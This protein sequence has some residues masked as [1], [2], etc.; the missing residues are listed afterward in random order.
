M[1]WRSTK[2]LSNPHC[3]LTKKPIMLSCLATGLQ[4]V[5][6]ERES[7]EDFWLI[8]IC[9]NIGS[10]KKQ[11]GDCKFQPSISHVCRCQ[12]SRSGGRQQGA[13]RLPDDRDA[14]RIDTAC[15]TAQ[16][17]PRLDSS[18][19]ILSSLVPCVLFSTGWGNSLSAG[20]GAF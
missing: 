7:G 16:S 18:F 10:R 17:L 8:L 14:S 15:S 12:R 20:F 9:T 19:L 13:H 3:F 2:A 11:L 4:T 5:T 1:P 6:G